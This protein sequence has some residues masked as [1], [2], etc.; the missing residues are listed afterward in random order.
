MS[1][2]PAP[3]LEKVIVN[4]IIKYIKKRFGAGRFVVKTH[5]G[6]F[7]ASGLPDIVLIAPG[8]RFVGL[9]VKRPGL[10]KVTALQNAVI[11]KINESGGYASVVY[12]VEDARAALDA[13]IR[14]DCAPEID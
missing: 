1:N 5:G 6:P 4:D 12:S 9:E 2:K 3:P 14:G 8:G 10:G 13:A 11:H 7:Q